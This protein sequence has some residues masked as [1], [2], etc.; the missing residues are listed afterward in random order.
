MFGKLIWAQHIN[1]Q[2][3]CT[4]VYNILSKIDSIFVMFAWQDA[5]WDSNLSPNHIESS[6][7]QELNLKKKVF[8]AIVHPSGNVP[9]LF[10]AHHKTWA[11]GSWFSLKN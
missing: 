11:K 9:S 8:V 10:N 3:T 1:L 7:A 4:M 5:V 6:L 2:D